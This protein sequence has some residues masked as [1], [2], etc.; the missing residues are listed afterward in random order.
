MYPFLAGKFSMRNFE[1]IENPEACYIHD[2]HALEFRHIDAVVPVAVIKHPLSLRW[3][4]ISNSITLTLL[5]SPLVLI[6]R[7]QIDDG[8]L[9]ILKTFLDDVYI[10]IVVDAVV[11]EI[12]FTNETFFTGICILTRFALKWW[13]IRH[14]TVCT[15]N[16]M[17]PLTFPAHDR[18]LGIKTCNVLMTFPPL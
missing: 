18:F 2:N 11:K 4:Q 17:L 13:P 8:P 10:L 15:L 7:R 6:H 9:E 12:I 14:L 3:D 1:E 16:F 5:S